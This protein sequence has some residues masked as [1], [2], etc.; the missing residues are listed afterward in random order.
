MNTMEYY[1][2]YVLKPWKNV[3]HKA[4]F[5]DSPDTPNRG[6]KTKTKKK[7]STNMIVDDQTLF[8]QF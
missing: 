4:N 5:T 7:I 2:I 3:V 8:W 6:K 1:L